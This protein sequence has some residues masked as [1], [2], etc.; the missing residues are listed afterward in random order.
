MPVDDGISN[1]STNRPFEDVLASHLSRRSALIGGAAT[2]AI[3]FLGVPSIAEATGRNDDD[4]DDDRR[5]RRRRKPLI[6]FAPV[7]NVD[8]PEGKPVP[9]ISSDYRYDVLIPWGSPL[10]PGGPDIAGGRPATEEEALQQ[11]GIGHDGMWFFPMDGRRCDRGVL[12][13]NHEFGSNAHVLGYPGPAVSLADVRISQAVHGNSVVEIKKGRGEW[14]PVRSRRS[15]RIT[16]NTPVVYDGPVAGSDH[17]RTPSGNAPL[18]TVNNCANGHTP[19]GTYLTC[20]E[21]FNGYF[22]WTDGAYVPSVEQRRYGF[23]AGGFGY[24]WHLHDERWDLSN[25][26]YTN[27]ENRFGWIV[28][29]DPMNPKS[30]PVKHTALGRVKHEGIA[31][32]EGKGGRIVGYMGDD[33]RFDYIYKFVS[34]D[35]WRKMRSRGTSP[36][37][38]GTLYVARFDDD[39]T[40]EWLELSPSNPA[41]ADKSLEW[42][43]VYTRLAADIAGATPMDRPEWTTVAPNGDVFCTLTN[44]SRRTV[45]DAANP[46]APNPNGHIIKFR[47]DDRHVGT[48]FE[49]D[50][51]VLAEPDTF[52][53]DF[54]FGSPDG[55]WA[56]PDGRLFIET[57]GGQPDT[58]N[59]LLV[60][61]PSTGEIRRLFVGVAGDEITGITVTPDRRTMFV[62]T[63]HPGDGDPGTS[64][65]PVELDPADPAGPIPR[66]STFVITRKDGG[67]IGS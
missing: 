7:L 24:G 63:Q 25:P 42:I 4:R 67:I 35:N 23:A 13:I 65:F 19:W 5:R 36:L 48:T 45:A 41:L 8:A 22:G 26:Q 38:E 17:L 18:G 66:D 47:D 16:P 52:G 56:D 64:N 15:R 53:T 29:I 62:N 55:L 2:A 49:W 51:F 6:G 30:A 50:I 10:R 28:E 21:N 46:L 20:E 1:L 34:S 33:E 11:I 43:L 58:N 27:E 37:S 14:R 61:D 40:G 31:I 32:T 9:T 54:S 3:A 59:Q 57:D 60:A 12:C 44:N 39:G